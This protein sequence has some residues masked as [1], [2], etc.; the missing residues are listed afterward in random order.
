ML[1]KDEL[2][3]V[4]GT[5]Y[6]PKRRCYF[7]YTTRSIGTLHTTP[8]QQHRAFLDNNSAGSSSDVLSG[9]KVVESHGHVYLP[10]RQSLS[11]VRQE[12]RHHNYK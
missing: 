3:V 10:D 7:R 2:D 11:G 9:P 1:T 4:I 5:S 8:E 12:R 6:K